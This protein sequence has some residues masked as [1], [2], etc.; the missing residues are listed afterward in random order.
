MKAELCNSIER[1]IGQFLFAIIFL[2]LCILLF[3]VVG[4]ALFAGV[5]RGPGTFEP[6]IRRVKFKR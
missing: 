2:F 4:H 5:K 3:A 6:F 1:S